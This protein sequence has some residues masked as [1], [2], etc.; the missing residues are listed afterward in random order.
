MPE[1]LNWLSSSALAQAL[2]ASPTLYLFVNAA[3]ILSI[4]L[5]VGAIVPLDLRLLGFFRHVPLSVI[6]PFLSRSA[7]IGAA[8]AIASGAMLF[9]VQASKYAANPAFIT[10]MGLLAVGIANA[11][12]FQAIAL[13]RRQSAYDNPPALVR[14]MAGLSLVTWIAAVVA[15]RWIGFV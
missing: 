3:H 12:I 2:T 7:M 15:G 4:A 10:K 9:S 13:W 6:G 1:L 5:L 8:F 14:I 11:L